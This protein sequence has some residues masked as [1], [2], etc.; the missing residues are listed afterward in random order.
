MRS[1]RQIEHTKNI[2]RNRSMKQIEK[3]P[4]VVGKKDN[5]GCMPFLGNKTS[6]GYGEYRMTLRDGTVIQ[7]A[8]RVAYYLEY[9]NITPGLCICHSCDNKICCNPEHLWMGTQQDNMDDMARKGRGTTNREWL[10]KEIIN[11]LDK[12]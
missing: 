9:G 5:N 2:D 1:K 12:S 4:K 7:G 10:D 3:F 6:K 11:V 8:H